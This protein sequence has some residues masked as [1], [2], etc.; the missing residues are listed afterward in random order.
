[1]VVDDGEM[2]HVGGDHFLHARLDGVRPLGRHHLGAPGAN[3]LHLQMPAAAVRHNQD[4]NTQQTTRAQ[5]RRDKTHTHTQT[6]KYARHKGT[7][8]QDRSRDKT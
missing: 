1:M 3:L 7:H 6:D 5:Q 2:A 8:I 4:V